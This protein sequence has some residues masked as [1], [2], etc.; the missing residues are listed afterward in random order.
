MIVTLLAA[1]GLLHV[2][3]GLVATASEH[4]RL[5]SRQ[6][7]FLTFPEGSAVTV[8]QKFLFTVFNNFLLHL[9]NFI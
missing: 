5:L 8:I 3:G 6:K 7:R 1:S 2:V 9:N 4:G